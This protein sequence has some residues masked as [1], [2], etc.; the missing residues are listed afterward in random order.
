MSFTPVGSAFTFI[1]SDRKGNTIV[2]SCASSGYLKTGAT[3]GFLYVPQMSGAPSSTGATGYTGTVAMCF[4]SQNNMP[5]YLNPNNTF[6]G[7]TGSALN[8]V[9]GNGQVLIGRSI[10]TVDQGEVI[11]SNIPQIF[12]SLM[13]TGIAR[14]TKAATNDNLEFQFNNDSTA[15]NYWLQILQGVNASVSASAGN[16]ITLVGQFPAASSTANCAGNFT[17]IIP[18]YSNTTFF[19]SFNS[20]NSYVASSASNAGFFNFGGQ[21]SNTSSI[22]S[23]RIKF[24]TGNILSGSRFRLYGIW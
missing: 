10:L 23:I 13:V 6:G 19:K 9:A 20:I 24:T 5:W 14:S 15:T 18:E 21:W 8:W 12:S 1:S 16:G 22:S 4:D 7:S 3:G 11:F 2:S 17:C